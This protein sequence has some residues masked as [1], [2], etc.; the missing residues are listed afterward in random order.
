MRGQRARDSGALL[1]WAG[2]RFGQRA[3]PRDRAKG[4]PSVPRK[5]KSAERRVM[6]TAKD[7]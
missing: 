7:T 1:P 4:L 5:I 6:P 3:D 2:C